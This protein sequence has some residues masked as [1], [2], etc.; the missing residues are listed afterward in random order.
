MKRFSVFIALC[1]T[2]LLAA[3][4][5]LAQVRAS[6]M[7][8]GTEYFRQREYEKALEIFERLHED[9]PSQVTYHYYYSCLMEL[10]D[11]KKAERLARQQ[12][13]ANPNSL[14]YKIDLGYVYMSSG[15]VSKGKRQYDDVIK[16]LEANHRFI[17]EAAN[18]FMLRRENEYAIKTYEKGRELLSGSYMFHM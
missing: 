4:D 16:N 17:N 1:L 13:R 14:R 3:G 18:A 9:N 10:N 7:Q 5:V 6:D 11:F 12:M 15:D 8:L 2:I